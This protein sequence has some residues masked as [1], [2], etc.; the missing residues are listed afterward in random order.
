MRICILFFAV[1]ILSTSFGCGKS[2]P[3][4]KFEKGQMVEAKLDGRTGM[5]IYRGGKLC[6]QYFVVR[7]AQNSEEVGANFLGLGS[8]DVSC[9][10]YV[11]VRMRDFELRGKKIVP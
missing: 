4:W 7:F 1:I 3:K 9:E 11:L 8:G 10:P 6:L 5:V 2:R